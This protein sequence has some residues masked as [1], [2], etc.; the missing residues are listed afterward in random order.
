M[1]DIKQFHLIKKELEKYPLKTQYI[2][3]LQL[4]KYIEKTDKNPAV[5]KEIDKL[6]KEIEGKFSN[7]SSWKRDILTTLMS[8]NND[9]QF[10]RPRLSKSQ[11]IEQ[12]IHQTQPK[13]LEEQQGVKYGSSQ[14]SSGYMEKGYFS[15]HK[16]DNLYA[17]KSSQLYEQKESVKE[18]QEEFATSGYHLGRKSLHEETEEHRKGKKGLYQR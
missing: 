7:D 4:Q 12:I 11:D 8:K 13:P 2:Y 5:L 1:V 18:K 6:L 9:D 16:G 17:A 15:K 14:E 3:L 10:E